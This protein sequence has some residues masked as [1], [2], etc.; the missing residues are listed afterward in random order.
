MI[1]FTVMMYVVAASGFIELRRLDWR[2]IGSGLAIAWIA[3]EGLYGSYRTL[4]STEPQH[5]RPIAA[6]LAAEQRPG[7]RIYVYHRAV[8]PLRYYAGEGATV[9]PGVASPHDP[10]F[11]E[12]QIGAL[13]GEPGRVWMVF[14][15]C[16]WAECSAIRRAAASRRTVE[17]VA[18]APG[19][20]LYLAEAAPFPP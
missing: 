2:S 6:V 10:A 15:L 19:T 14:S 17:R 8:T 13:L 16:D 5:V 9:I 18:T 20:E 1:V 4:F 11:H 7:D 12:R 3:A